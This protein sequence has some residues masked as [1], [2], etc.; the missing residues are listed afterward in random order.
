MELG[1]L[2][3]KESQVMIEWTGMPEFVQ[4]D[5]SPYKTVKIHFRNKDDEAD[6]FSLINQRRT[7]RNSYWYPEALPRKT[8]D[9]RYIDEP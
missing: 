5:L 3:K 6:F 7:K 2:T 1:D 9:K 8:A 4:Q